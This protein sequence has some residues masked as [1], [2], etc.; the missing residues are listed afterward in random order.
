MSDIR[1]V[2]DGAT[3]HGDWVLEGGDLL[4]DGDL[5]TAMLLSVFTDGMAAPD[6]VI[7]DGTGD[8]RGWWGDQFDPTR[9]IGS[10]LWLLE[11][12]KQTQ[13]TLNR[14]YDYLAECLQWLIDDG[15]VSRFDI[16]VEWTRETFLGAQIIAFSPGGDALHTGKYLWAWNGIN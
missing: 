4:T 10:K 12:E 13:R 9:P 14:A 15:V 2:W 11:R 7:P 16:K 6:D 3:V 5:A 8:P 1:I